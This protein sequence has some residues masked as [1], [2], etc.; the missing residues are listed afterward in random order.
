MYPKLSNGP[1][2][3]KSCHNICKNVLMLKYESVEFVFQ[4]FLGVF[5]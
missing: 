4:R 2:V 3:Q 1:S 5:D